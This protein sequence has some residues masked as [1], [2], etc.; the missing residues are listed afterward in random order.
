MREHAPLTS[1]S[2]NVEDGIENFSQAVDPWSAIPFGARHV[3]LNVLPLIMVE[4]CW[5]RFSHAC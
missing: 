1:A 4:I 2:Q 5:V 3:R